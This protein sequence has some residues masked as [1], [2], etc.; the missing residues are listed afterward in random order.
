[1]VRASC[2]R[3]LDRES[4]VPTGS[5]SVSV[6]DGLVTLLGTAH[7]RFQ[8][9]AAKRAVATVDGVKGVVDNIIIVSDPIPGTLPPASRG[10][11]DTKG[12]ASVR[13]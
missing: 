8:A 5:V 9:A 3:A 1:M 6:E 2:L 12:S 4:H 10:P 11:Y 13:T 7:H